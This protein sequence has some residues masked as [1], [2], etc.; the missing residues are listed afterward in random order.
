MRIHDSCTTCDV[1]SFNAQDVFDVLVARTSLACEHAVR[2]A[3]AAGREKEGELATTS[4]EFEFHLQFPCGSPSTELSDFRQSTRSGNELEC[5]QNIEKHVPRI[6]T[7]L[8]MSSPPISILH[9][10][11]QC[12]Y[13]NSRDVVAS[14]SSFY[15]PA[16][17]APRR[18]CLQARTSTVGYGAFFFVGGSHKAVENSRKNI[19][20]VQQSCFGL[21]QL[22]F[23]FWAFSL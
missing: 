2:S 9:R 20:K 12:R 8:L 17:R 3:L 15:R 18:A 13:S 10:L 14:F 23:N 19:A 16:A 7:S 5:K 22:F 21:V 11:F 1:I 4:L 6:M